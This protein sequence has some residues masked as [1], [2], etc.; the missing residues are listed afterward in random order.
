VVLA[1]RRS[2]L[3]AVRVRPCSSVCGWAAPRSRS[4]RAG[5]HQR[6]RAR[7]GL[8]LV[9]WGRPDR[10]E[11]GFDPD[12]A[13]IHGHARTPWLDRRHPRHAGWRG[14]GHRHRRAK[15]RGR[16]AGALC[17]LGDSQYERRPGIRRP[18]HT[19]A[20]APG[21]QAVGARG[22]AGSRSR[23]RGPCGGCPA[24]RIGRAGERDRSGSRA[25]VAIG[26]AVAVGDRTCRRVGANGVAC[27]RGAAGTG[28]RLIFAGCCRGAGFGVG[29]RRAFWTLDPTPRSCGRGARFHPCAGVGVQAAC[30]PRVALDPGGE[31]RAIHRL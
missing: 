3:A 11:D 22:G 24:A 8:G 27:T 20:L 13:R 5:G 7:G 30:S 18:T 10:R 17:V 6:A 29:R 25:R 16:V 23:R 9:C 28:G 15:R 19:A 2:R 14:L 31:R 1:G 4:R 12:T 21:R 26:T